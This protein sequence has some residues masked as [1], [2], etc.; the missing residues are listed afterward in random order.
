VSGIAD[1]IRISS[2]SCDEAGD[3][4]LQSVAEICGLSPQLGLEPAVHTSEALL[5]RYL[6]GSQLILGN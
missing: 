4:Q 3:G 5:V 1:I 2:N 6:N